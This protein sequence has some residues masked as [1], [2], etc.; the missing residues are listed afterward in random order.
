MIQ[1]EGTLVQ[2]LGTLR[3]YSGMTGYDGIRQNFLEALSD[4]AVEAIVLDIDSPGGEVAGCFDLVDTI[5]AARGEKP[6]WS[7]LSESAYSAGYAIAS[8]ADRIVVPRTGGTGSI[9]VISMHVDWSQA[10]TEAGVKVTFITY[11]ERK[12][13]GHPE[14]PLSKEA[15]TRFQADIDTMGALFVATV[16]RNRGMS[17][18]QVRQTEAGTFM[19]EA[20]VS[21]GLADAVMSPDAAFRS[22]IESIS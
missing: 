15:L 14:I 11:G 22:L 4:P 21:A 17:A 18:E 7:V 5:Y 13:D 2:K 9:G 1:V 3:P 16:A 20:G 8:A 6:I 12:A 10:L 19:G